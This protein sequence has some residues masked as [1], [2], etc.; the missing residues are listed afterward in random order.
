MA[1]EGSISVSFDFNDTA[2]S[3][4]VD[5]LKKVRL[6]SNEAITAGKIAVVSGTVGTTLQ[7]IDLTSLTYRNAA[8]DLVTLAEIDRV[9]IQADRSVYIELVDTGTKIHA[10]DNKVSVSCV[11][12]T[13]DTLWVYTTSGTSSYAVAFHGL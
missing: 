8:G 13:D 4:G 10:D 7:T 3:T 2:S 12:N 11:H 1:I 9:A 5:V 6:A